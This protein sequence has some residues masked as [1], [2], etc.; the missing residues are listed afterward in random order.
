MAD[1]PS[2]QKGGQSKTV[3]V[4]PAAKQVPNP[5]DLNKIVNNDMR[6]SVSSS[7]GLL[8]NSRKE[9]I[10]I[11]QINKT[12]PSATRPANWGSGADVVKVRSSG[13]SGESGVLGGQHA[14]GHSDVAGARGARG[15][16]G[17]G[18]GPESFGGGGGLPRENM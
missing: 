2:Y 12:A 4:V 11:K 18:G 7:D 15:G 16:G 14:G 17:F 8:G 3:K 10:Q 13:L 6:R 9:S 5:P 1:K